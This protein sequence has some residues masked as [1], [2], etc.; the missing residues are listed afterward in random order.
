M[1][2]SLGSDF[3]KKPGLVVLIVVPGSQHDRSCQQQEQVILF[4][5]PGKRP[6]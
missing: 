1:P 3:L 5:G 6:Q 2:T 4:A